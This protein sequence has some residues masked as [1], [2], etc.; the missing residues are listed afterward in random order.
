MAVSES[1]LDQLGWVPAS[2][3][4]CWAP[5]APETEASW[6]AGWRM[7]KAQLLRNLP[8]PPLLQTS[9]RKEASGPEF[10]EFL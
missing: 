1:W 3:E 8:P 7:P 6:S 9:Q 4:H 2:K 5:K 10:L